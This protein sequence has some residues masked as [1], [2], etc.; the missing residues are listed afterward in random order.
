MVEGITRRQFIRRGAGAAAVA[1]LGLGGLAGCGAGRGAEEG[2]KAG[3]TVE[4]QY[5]HINT[6]SLGGATV[7]ELVGRFGEQNP[8]MRVRE[9]FFE[10]YTQLLEGLQTSL[11]SETPPDVAQIGYPY[12]EYVAAN[13]PY[14][15]AEELAAQH[16]GDGFFGG[17][18]D[19]LLELGRVEGRQ[20]G[21]PYSIS[22][23][24]TYYNAD[25][26]S[27][28][29]L[30]PDAPPQTWEEWR[31]ASQAV[32][33]E[34]GKAG[35]YILILDDNWSAQAIIESNGGRMLGCEGGE[36]TA[37]FDSPEA[38][39]AIGF[40]ASVVEDDLALNVLREQGSQAFL[41]GEVA[42]YSTSIAARAGLEEQ[43][44]F[45]LR[46]APFPSFGSKRP[47]LPAGGNNLFVFSQDAARQEAAWRFLEFLESPESLAAWTEGTGYL[48]PREG[49][50]EDFVRENPIQAV[51][52]EQSPLIVPWASFP[53]PNGLQASQA[54]FGELQ[55]ALGG[56]SS[57]EDALREAAREVDELIAGQPCP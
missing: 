53:G 51:A 47:A 19:N 33:E 50:A 25:L 46:G 52:V 29:G 14:T 32:R 41:S 8:S 27:R 10:D 34:T 2:S 15:P 11:A 5:W 3:E 9:R 4:I 26:L 42:A 23:H 36:A 22:N 56:Q 30:D 12:L 28:A 49:V 20:V 40:W 48:T 54:L 31:E 38:V 44:S 13:F 16:A 18:Q 35:F 6:E 43:V 57:A 24:L 55:E 7:K 21:M 39:E 1:G 45:D 17:F 37:T